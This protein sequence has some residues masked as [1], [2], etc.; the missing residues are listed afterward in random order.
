MVVTRWNPW[1]DLFS[2]HDQVFNDAIGRTFMPERV[3]HSLP[4]D[5]RQ[6]DEAFLIEASLPGFKPEDVE[7]TFDE[8]VLTIRGTRQEEEISRGG[9]VQRE[10]HLNSV[11]RQVGLPA[12]I[13]ADEITA[14]FDN[15]I[16]TVLVPRAQKA[17]PMRIP[18][19]VGRVDQ[20]KL[21]DAAVVGSTTG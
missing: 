16:L 18:L 3:V 11:Y 10:R 7:V 13:K 1:T 8:N 5:V 2:L 4:L 20:P 9:Y 15:G 14:S 12:E 19:T 6:T 21:I 17:Q